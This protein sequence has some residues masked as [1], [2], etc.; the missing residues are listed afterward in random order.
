M[1]DS[2][3]EPLGLTSTFTSVPPL[4]NNSIV[5]FNDTWSG[6]SLDFRDE[7]PAAGYYSSINDL[8]QIGKSMLNST[9]LR[10]HVT[11]RWMKP[12]SF[13]G[14]LNFSVGS[15]WE[16]ARASTNHLMW[17]YTKGGHVGNYATEIILVPDLEIGFTVLTAG[18]AVSN[19]VDLLSNLLSKVI[20]PA[21]EEAA[22]QEARSIYAGTYVGTYG[23]IQVLVDNG[24]GLKIGNW[25]FNGTDAAA[26]LAE[27]ALGSPDVDFEIRLWPTTLRSS[28][29]GTVSSSWRAVVQKLPIV[30]NPFLGD[31]IS[32]FLIDQL[33]YG[34]VGLDEFV[35][36]LN[37]QGTEATQIMPRGWRTSYNRK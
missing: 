27:V 24:P 21:A 16:I 26:V 28:S 12:I 25:T 22:R 3:I 20:V 9:L 19:D 23:S 17:M 5:P 1:Q 11:R 4:S 33:T 10:P 15:P 13:T 18:A 32:W 35:F 36:T 14:S 2:L 7:N 30:A 31:C 6:Y 8:R 37:G 34:G 29:K